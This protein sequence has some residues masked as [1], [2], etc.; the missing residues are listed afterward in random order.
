M[1]EIKL[2]QG[3][4]ALVDDEDYDK[5]SQY[6]WY[7][8]KQG[9]S[10]YAIVHNGY[11]DG[12]RVLLKMHRVIMG[13]TNPKI[14]VD[15]KDSDGLNNQKYNLRTATVSQNAAN[16]A[17]Y[18]GVSKYKGVTK[19]GKYWKAMCTKDGISHRKKCSTEIEAALWYNQKAT[20][21]HG[22]FAKLNIVYEIEQ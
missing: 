21:L 8:N 9:N 19:E 22:E 20:E 15:H 12:K 16:K 14:F 11:L 18:R 10:Y 7:A 6:P 2:S 5:I 3:K 17:S 13:I 1:K 4:V